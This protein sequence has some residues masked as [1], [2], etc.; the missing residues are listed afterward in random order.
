VCLSG[1]GAGTP[2][3]PPPSDAAGL[4]ADAAGHLDA[5]TTFGLTMD[6]A[7]PPAQPTATPGAAA[8]PLA[9]YTVDLTGMWNATSHDGTMKGKLN[10]VAS[11]VLAA[12]GVEYISLAPGSGAPAGK[13][14]LKV[15][16]GDGTFGAFSDPHLVAQL[17]RAYHGVRLVAAHHVTG[18]ILTSEADQHIADPNLVASLAGYPDTIGFDI[19]TDAAGVPTRI[20]FQLGLEP[21]RTSG[22]VVLHD[23]GA[24]APEVQVPTAAQVVEA[25]AHG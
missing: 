1:C 3:S 21:A 10:G 9:S 24:A 19:A 18:T 25:P 20:A 7:V 5:A 16:G 15:D 13:T 6:T 2:S 8:G 12:D 17:L 4:L 22:S 11:T 23:F 14:W